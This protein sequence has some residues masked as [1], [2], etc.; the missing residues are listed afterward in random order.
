MQ[1]NEEVLIVLKNMLRAKK[2]GIIRL[3]HNEELAIS[4]AIL[5]IENSR[6]KSSWIRI[7]KGPSSYN[8][9]CKNCGHKFHSGKRNYCPNCGADMREETNDVPN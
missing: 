1:T 3:L 7:K 9:I 6:P 8:Y 5:L 4:Q 2:L